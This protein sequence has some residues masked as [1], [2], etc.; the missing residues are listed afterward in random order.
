MKGTLIFNREEHFEEN[1]F[2]M[3]VNAKKAYSALYDLL[4][5]T[6]NIVEDVITELRADGYDIKELDQ[7]IVSSIICR[8]TNRMVVANDVNMDLYE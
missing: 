3:A 1:E 8:F 5:P 6:Q 4:N 2:Q 7:D